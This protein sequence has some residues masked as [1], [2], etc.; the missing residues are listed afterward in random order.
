MLE[1]EQTDTWKVNSWPEYIYVTE[2]IVVLFQAHFVLLRPWKITKW[3]LKQCL[4]QVVHVVKLTLWIKP[5]VDPFIVIE[6]ANLSWINFAIKPDFLAS[7]FIMR[8]SLPP[9]GASIENGLDHMNE[10]F[11]FFPKGVCKCLGQ[12]PLNTSACLLPSAGHRECMTLP[13]V[14]IKTLCGTFPVYY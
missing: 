11:I 8:K 13:S 3:E 6:L 4:K 14:V 7:N 2:S 10:T 1:S 9:T 12:R 5:W